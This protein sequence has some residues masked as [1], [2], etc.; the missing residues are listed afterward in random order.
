MGF[1]RTFST[2]DI[3]LIEALAVARA[4]TSFWAFRCYMNPKMKKGWWQRKIAEELQVFYEDI[5]AGKRPKLVIQAPPQHG[6]SVIIIDFLAWVAGQNPDLKTIFASFSDRLGVRANRFLQ[7]IYDSAKYRRIFPNTRI[8]AQ[9]GSWVRNREMLEYIDHV[10]YFRNTTVRG[11]VTGESLDLGVIDDPIKGRAEANS[12]SVRDGAWEWLTDDFLTRFSDEGA[13]LIILT[14][15]H[16]DDP[17]GRLLAEDPEVRVVTYPAIAIEDEEFRKV[18]D[19]L[20]P[21]HKSLEFLLARKAILSESSW[22]SLYQQSPFIRSGGM[23]P[24]DKFVIVDTFDPTEV[25][26]SIRYWDKAGTK[27]GDGAETAGVLL[28]KLRDGTFLV[29]HLVHGRWAALEREKHIKTWTMADGIGVQSHVEQEPGSGGKE[30]AE[31]TIRNNAGFSVY[32]DRPSGDKV[33]RAEPYAAQ[34]Q[35]GN[36]KVLR[37]PWNKAFLECHEYFPNGKTKDIVDASSGAFN[38]L[39]GQIYDLEALIS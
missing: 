16:V 20:F 39:F 26:K 1:Q 12:P 4:R 37:G 23:F 19:P 32:A 38:K 30:S 3:D 17:V 24:I 6:K 7:R 15:W 14:R 9:G 36:V 34:V 35:G 5:V 31:S 28:H 33:V 25:L 2:R 22:E 11:S 21:E 27:D 10:G 18:G 13:L 29:E 8:D